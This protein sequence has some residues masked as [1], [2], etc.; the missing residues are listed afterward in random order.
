MR[1][2][3][4]KAERSWSWRPPTGHRHFHQGRRAD[5]GCRTG[6]VVIG[7]YL[8]KPLWC[9]TTKLPMRDAK[10]AITGIIGISKDVR[11]PV[12]PQAPPGVAATLAR[13]EAG[14]G[15]AAHAFRTRPHREA[16]GRA[17]CP[18]RLTHLRHH[19]HPAHLENAHRR[20]R[21]PPPRARPP[22][23]RHRA[24]MRLLRPQRLHPRL[25][26]RGRRDPDAIPRRVSRA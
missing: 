9:L 18:H 23:R 11:A 8:G 1:E 22:R 2:A 21:P 17:L 15:E 6:S 26:R 4:A 13:L 19:T 12:A 10:G 20:R 14:Y 24:R 7:A 5:A 16:A 25:P 3:G